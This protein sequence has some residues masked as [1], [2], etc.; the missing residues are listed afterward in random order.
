MLYSKGHKT[1]WGNT[2][3]G[4]KFSKCFTVTRMMTQQRCFAKLG[5]I[6]VTINIT[7]KI[8]E[9]LL[10]DP[11][12]KT[13][14]TIYWGSL[15]LVALLGVCSNRHSFSHSLKPRGP[16]MLTLSVYNNTATSSTIFLSL[17][18]QV[19]SKHPLL[20][21]QVFMAALQQ[22]PQLSHYMG[23]TGCA[24]LPLV[25]STTLA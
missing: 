13:E 20:R 16:V 17:T 14:E 2:S 22:I 19:T 21:L 9:S 7:E 1:L 6:I 11:L 5:F 3:A 8:H 23:C 12:T 25:R 15:K 4:T 24:S 10:H 18:P